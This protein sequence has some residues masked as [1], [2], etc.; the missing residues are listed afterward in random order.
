MAWSHM[1]LTKHN[2]WR[3]EEEEE[4]DIMEERFEMI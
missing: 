2:Q 1:V 4:E 3:E